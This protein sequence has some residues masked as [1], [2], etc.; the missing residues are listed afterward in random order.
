[1]ANIQKHRA[2]E[3]LNMDSAAD[4]Q[5]QGATAIS[6]A[7]SFDVSNYHTVHLQSDENIYFDFTTSSTDALV[8]ADT[9]YLMGGDTIYSL[10]VPKALGDT[11]Y[12]WIEMK[13]TPASVRMVFA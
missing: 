7:A 6:V 13:S 3:S 11:I 12:L 10:K 8:P 9:L 4:W 1:M 2:H 5:N